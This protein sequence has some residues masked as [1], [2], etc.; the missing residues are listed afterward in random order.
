M[1]PAA[2]TIA[3]S[4]PSGGAGLQADL[5]TF[6]RFGVYGEAAVTLVTVQNTE[7]VTR[8]DVLP[9][10]LVRAQVEA[11][12]ADIPPQ[13]VKTGALGDAAVIEALAEIVFP[14]PLIVDPVMISTRGM[15]L[16]DAAGRR[17]L[18]ELLLPRA[19]LFMP[20]LDEAAEL[21]G[22]PVGDLASMRR[23][24]EALAAAGARNVLIK[25]GHLT[26]EAVDLLR[27]EDGQTEL[28]EAPRIDARH[29]HGTGCTYSAAI[30]AEIAKGA[31]LQDA[32][33]KAKAF[34]TAAIRGA[35]GLGRGSGPV[36]H[37][38]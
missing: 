30:T 33:S 20:N 35:P 34:I 29:T 1:R 15:P 32:V 27:T 16:L 9:A 10:G 13:A 2:L 18:A 26:T 37:W 17:A 19:F 31:Q 21:A 22:F 12:L 8:V 4:D 7:A 6:H 3:G 36:D 38:A 24:A 11:V 25:G 23:A 28:F 5:K 14:C